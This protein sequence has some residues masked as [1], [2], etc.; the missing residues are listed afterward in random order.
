M[1]FI[2]KAINATQSAFQKASR[3]ISD[4]IDNIIVFPDDLLNFKDPTK[5]KSM[6]EERAK[7]FVT[8]SAEGITIHK[9]G[10]G[11]DLLKEW[12]DKKP[13]PKK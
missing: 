12:L 9:N 13:G 8:D 4:K 7:R 10:T 5:P 6:S 1:K 3:K 2:R 11:P